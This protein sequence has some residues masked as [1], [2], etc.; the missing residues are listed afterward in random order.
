MLYALDILVLSNDQ[1]KFT[2]FFIFWTF[3]RK[4]YCS[5]SGLVL[6]CYQVTESGN[7]HAHCV[8]RQH[9]HRYEMCTFEETANDCWWGLVSSK[10]EL[11][12][13]TPL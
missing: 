10:F 4:S 3:C 8:T 12:F 6:C 13:D 5:C 7:A 11:R 2:V 9:S 1:K